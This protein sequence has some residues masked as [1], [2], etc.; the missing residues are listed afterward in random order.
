M[1]QVADQIVFIHR[2]IILQSRRV[3]IQSQ[4]PL[5]FD[6]ALQ[7]GGELLFGSMKRSPFDQIGSRCR[8]HAACQFG[9]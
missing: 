5:Q 4:Q 1:A 3:F 9:G 8:G 2:M 6:F 7:Q